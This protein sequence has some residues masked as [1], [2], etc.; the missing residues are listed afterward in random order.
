MRDRKRLA[1]ELLVGQ[2]RAQQ[3]EI[4]APIDGIV[5]T[6]NVDQETGQYLLAGDEFAHLVDRRSMKARI[7]VQD[8]DIQDVYVG[9]PAEVKVLPFPFH[10]YWGHIDKLSPAA[11]L[12]HPIA[13]IQKLERL[14]QNLTN[15][16]CLLYTSRCV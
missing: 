6:P 9:A 1:Q 13:Q 16:L 5:V 3:L 8:R 14:G 4:R 10:T 7:L 12:D 15:Y 11:A 2:K